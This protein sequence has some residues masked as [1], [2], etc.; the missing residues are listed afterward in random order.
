M[1]SCTLTVLVPSYNEA[2][3][4]EGSITELVLHL[5]RLMGESAGWFEVI[6]CDNGST[7]D[8]ESKVS[9]LLGEYAEL[10]YLRV[11]EKGFGRALR[12]GIRVSSGDVIT[13]LPADGEISLKFL[14]DGLKCMGCCDFVSGSRYLSKDVQYGSGFRRLLSIAYVFVFRFFFNHGLSE[15][16]TVK[17][18]SGDWARKING[19]CEENGWGWQV[20]M[21]YWAIAD[22]RR[23]S[24]IP[25]ESMKKRSSKESKVN[26][27]G[28]GME[29]FSSTVEYGLRLRLGGL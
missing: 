19:R 28:D 5:R 17:M 2:G 23:V 15:V 25:V 29:F 12:N 21:L 13:F 3:V 8:T 18:F 6:V 4:L 24:E 27:L 11:D 16:G 7:D 10:K 26:V 22:K 9:G 14:G 1:R 20:E